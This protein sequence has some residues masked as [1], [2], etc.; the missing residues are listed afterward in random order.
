MREPN[1][2]AAAVNNWQ[3]AA[4]SGIG[5]CV[6]RDGGSETTESGPPRTSRLATTIDRSEAVAPHE[7][8]PPGRWK[9]EPYANRVMW[10]TADWH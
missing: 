2:V 10:I 7:R 9:S 3:A 1:S 8:A 6:L 4:E 5:P